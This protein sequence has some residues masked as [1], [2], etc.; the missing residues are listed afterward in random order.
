[1]NNFFP[2]DAFYT[3]TPRYRTIDL[4]HPPQWKYKDYEDYKTYKPLLKQKDAL[5]RM[6]CVEYDRLQ[7]CNDANVVPETMRNFNITK[8]KKCRQKE[9]GNGGGNGGDNGGGNGGK[10]SKSECD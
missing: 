5:H 10:I 1:M 7:K 8:P 2:G 6:H 9:N 4:E 3:K